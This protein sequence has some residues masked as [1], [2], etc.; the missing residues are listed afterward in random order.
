MF[1]T[2]NLKKIIPIITNSV[3]SCKFE[4][5]RRGFCFATAGYIA[6]EMFSEGTTGT[7]QCYRVETGIE[8]KEILHNTNGFN[9]INMPINFIAPVGKE[10]FV[11]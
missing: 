10:I 7:E 6:F 11:L 2:F 5:I 9:H 3:S 8:W 4:I 1:P